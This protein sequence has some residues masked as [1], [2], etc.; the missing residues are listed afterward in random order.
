MRPAERSNARLAALVLIAA[1]VGFLTWY[2]QVWRA[3]PDQLATTSDFAPTYVAATLWRSGEAAHLYDEPVEQQALLAT[4]APPD[5]LNIPYENP[6]GALLLAVPLTPLGAVGAYRAWSLLQLA[7]LVAGVAITVRAAPWRP[8]TSAWVRVA[9]GAVAIAGYGTGL[10]FVEAQWDGFSV[11]GLGLAY[12][13]WR[14][15]RSAGGGFALGLGSAI[16]KPHLI[17]GLGG[18]VL[19]RRDWRALA[20]MVAGGLVMLAAA[21]LA[22]GSQGLSSYLGAVTKPSNSPPRQMLSAT[23]LIASWLGSGRGAYALIALVSLAALAA[24]VWVGHRSRGRTLEL[25]LGTATAL[26]LFCAPHLLVHDL[27][28]L[29]PAL[30]MVA[31]RLTTLERRWPGRPALALIAAWVVLGILAQRDLGNDAAAPPGRFVPWVLMALGIA[32]VL[33]L[34][35]AETTGAAGSALVGG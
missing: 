27:T 11:L 6:P 9:V 14:R 15:G 20:G 35:R 16:A 19:G 29:A 5:H 12:A 23:G 22:A 17:L 28:M 30:V 26:S 4:G 2:A 31:A 34:R 24:A 7:L 32:G 10:L 21:L 8:Q 3:V 18:F 25:P 1:A 33:A 13:L